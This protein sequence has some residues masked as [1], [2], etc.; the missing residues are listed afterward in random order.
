M[1]WGCDS[2]IKV[3]PQSEGSAKLV[4]TELEMER[5][6]SVTTYFKGNIKINDKKSPVVDNNK[7]EEHPI[8]VH[9]KDPNDI[10]HKVDND[11]W[12]ETIDNM[13]IKEALK[14]FST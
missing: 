14:F 13:T 3:E 4:I 11:G 12:K 2:M 5:S 9:D 10:V 1:K 6:F 7:E 8:N